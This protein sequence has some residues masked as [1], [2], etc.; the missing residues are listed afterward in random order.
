MGYKVLK[1]YRWA[2]VDCETTGL[3]IKK[4]HLIKV[5]VMVVTE[6]G[7]EARF[8]SLIKPPSRIPSAIEQLTGIT[9]ELVR[10]APSFAELADNLSVLLKNCIFVAHNARLNYG[11]LK[12]SLKELGISLSMPV[13]CTIKLFKK[14]YP[15]A[16][17]HAPTDLALY[18]E[19]LSSLQHPKKGDLLLLYQLLERAEKDHGLLRFLKEA[20]AC[21]KQ[22]SIPSKLKTDL[23]SVPNSPG[24]YLFYGQT[25]TPIY[26]GKSVTI[27]QRVLSHFQADYSHPKEFKMAQQVERV[28]FITTAGEL[29]ALILESHLIKQYSPVFNR[30][31]RRKKTMVSFSLHEH[32]DGYLRIH[33]HRQ[34]DDCD[35]SHSYGSFS[36]GNHAKKA[37]LELQKVHQLCPK[38]CGLEQSKSACFSYQ[39]KRCFGACVQ[40][41]NR[42]NYNERVRQALYTIKK[43]AW[44]FNGAIAIKEECPLSKQTHWMKFNQWRYL[45]SVAHEEEL[46]SLQDLSVDH[47]LDMYRI[48]VGYMN[49]QLKSEQTV[50]A[51]DLATEGFVPQ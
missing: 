32:Q 28:E 2:I 34:A 25:T 27:R 33:T 14:L 46:D 20:K 41:E 10:L 7:I 5:S 40:E 24:V 35:S 38:L 1:R 45:G 16:P 39:L 44:P 12:N 37:L 18:Q 30:K 51:L 50:F 23:S 29:S 11:F 43:R 48:L 21:Y 13:L 19:V 6:S 8:S 9:N 26:I 15:H 42:L 4:D 22:S 17:S 49:S 31:L 3:H 47:D 36:N